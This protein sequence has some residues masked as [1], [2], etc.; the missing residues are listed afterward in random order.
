MELQFHQDFLNLFF[1]DTRLGDH[2][3]DMQS[4]IFDHTDHNFRRSNPPGCFLYVRE[5][6]VQQ[7]DP[8]NLP[9]LTLQVSLKRFWMTFNGIPW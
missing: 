3:K 6:S 5:G 7:F 2:D 8:N 9:L 4:L 1:G